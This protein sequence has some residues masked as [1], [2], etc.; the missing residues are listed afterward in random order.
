M[1]IVTLLENTGGSSSLRAEHG[2]SLYVETGKYKI[3]FDM[4]QTDAFARNARELGI[5]LSQV[6]F[7]VLSHGHYDHGGGLETFLNINTKAPVFV[8]EEVF[9]SYYNGTEKYIGLPASLMCSPRLIRGA[10]NRTLCPGIHLLDCNDQHWLFN[11]YGLNR[12]EGDTFI[13][14][15]FRHEQYLEIREG[16]SRFLFTGCSHKG[17]ENIVHYF[18]PD[19]LIGGFHLNK[20]QDP[21]TLSRIAN[22]LKASKTQCHTGHCTGHMQFAVLFSHLGKHVDQLTTGMQIMI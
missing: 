2:L 1:K 22:I 19:V 17:I 14:D 11:S 5:D 10:G 13:P 8:Q 20:E 18:K 6:D 21:Q 16:T 12:R 7:A 15:D 9:G 3:L 4:G